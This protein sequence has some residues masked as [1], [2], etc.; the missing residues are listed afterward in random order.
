MGIF[1]LFRFH[2]VIWDELQHV[3]RKRRRPRVIVLNLLA[4][5]VMS[6]P[7]GKGYHLVISWVAHLYFLLLLPYAYNKTK[8]C[9]LEV[10]TA[11]SFG[12]WPRTFRLMYKGYATRMMVLYFSCA[13][14]VVVKAILILWVAGSW[15]ASIF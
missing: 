5:L 7:F 8:V 2:G 3:M 11:T 13:G 9:P 6:L 12:R 10:M 4:I 14:L 1:R 15:L